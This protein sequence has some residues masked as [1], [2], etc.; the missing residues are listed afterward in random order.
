[1]W[2]VCK[3]TRLPVISLYLPIAKKALDVL[4]E[5]L[6]TKNATWIKVRTRYFGMP[7]RMGRKL[8]FYL[9]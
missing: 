7:C 3:A 6:L 9:Y 2:I 4:K 8:G 5:K 1:M